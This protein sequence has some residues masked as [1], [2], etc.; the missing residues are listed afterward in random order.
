M[1]VPGDADQGERVPGRG[2]RLRRRIVRRG[3][4]VRR[5]RLSVA[6]AGSDP[7]WATERRLWIFRGVDLQVS[8]ISWQNLRTN[9]RLQM[10]SCPRSGVAGYWVLGCVISADARTNLA[11]LGLNYAALLRDGASATFDPTTAAQG[12]AAARA[13]PD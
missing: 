11:Q 12:P 3:G 4:A 5:E 6:D 13:S 10:G 8:R 2:R 9:S 7:S 1:P